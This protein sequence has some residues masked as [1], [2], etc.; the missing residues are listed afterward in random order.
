MRRRIL[1]VI[2]AAALGLATVAMLAGC[3]QIIG[4]VVKGAAEK[5]TG[6]SV[7]EQN[8]ATT[9]TGKNGQVQIGTEKNK[10]AD[11]FPA[12]FPIWPGA[13]ITSSSKV[14]G[15]QGGTYT[16]EL[17]TSDSVDTVLKGYKDKLTSA[18]YKIQSQAS[19]S[20]GNGAGGIITF[21]GGSTTSGGGALTVAQKDGST[22]ISVILNVKK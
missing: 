12:E 20:S 14:T 1:T 13:T 5:A 17:T 15:P 2:L 4:N 6:V 22:V 10:L 16:A 8:G 3:G 9:I 21:Q 19:G 18:G 11:G 7:N